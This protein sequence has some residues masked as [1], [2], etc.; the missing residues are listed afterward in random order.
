ME[1]DGAKKKETHGSASLQ[2]ISEKLKSSLVLSSNS[3]TS[4]ESGDDGGPIGRE[5]RRRLVEWWSRE[6]SASRMRLC[7]ISEGVILY[8]HL[9]TISLMQTW[10]IHWIICLI[11]QPVCSRP[12]QIT[13]RTLYPRFRTILLALTRMVYVPPLRRISELAADSSYCGDRPWSPCRQSWTFML[14]IYLFR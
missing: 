7:V 11:W 5:T 8:L 9:I 13:D 3:T 10:K 6:Y 1:E 12:Y 14:W 4:L 2:G